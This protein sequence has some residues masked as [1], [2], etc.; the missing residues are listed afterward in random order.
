LLGEHHAERQIEASSGCAQAIRTVKDFHMRCSILM[1]TLAL[2]VVVDL[3]VCLAEDS[4]TDNPVASFY[5]GEVP[6]DWNLIGL[7][8]PPGKGVKDVDNV[9][10]CWVDIT[11]ATIYFG[12]DTNWR[13]TWKSAGSWQSGMAKPAWANRKPNGTHPKDPFA[14]GP[15]EDKG[16]KYLGATEP[17]WL[18]ATSEQFPMARPGV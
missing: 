16:G 5:G 11:G 6:R 4:P 7:R 15:A 3:A 1:S 18:T 9:G 8:P 13:P 14:G 12:F 2:V 10:V 17:F